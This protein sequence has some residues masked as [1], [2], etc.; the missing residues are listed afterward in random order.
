[1]WTHGLKINEIEGLQVV[2]GQKLCEVRSTRH[3][4]HLNKEI[5]ILKIHGFRTFSLA[6]GVATIWKCTEIR[7]D[8]MFNLMVTDHLI[9]DDD[10]FRAHTEGNKKLYGWWLMNTTI[11]PI[12]FWVATGGGQLFARILVRRVS[13][14]ANSFT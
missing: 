5:L 9:T 7:S 10:Y 3:S 14:Y 2:S 12:P 6:I 1:V 4:R 8:V 11:F 13:L